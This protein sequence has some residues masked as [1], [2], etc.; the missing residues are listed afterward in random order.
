MSPGLT[1]SVGRADRPAIPPYRAGR[2]EGAL[3]RMIGVRF[4]VPDDPQSVE[5]LALLASTSAHGFTLQVTGLEPVHPLFATV[6]AEVAR[7][8]D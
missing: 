5:L 3:D 4:D 1:I 2:I 6:V 7:A 8:Q